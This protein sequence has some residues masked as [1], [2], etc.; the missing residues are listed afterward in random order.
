MNANM[1]NIHQ[2]TEAIE[3]TR[4]YCIHT[5]KC[6]QTG[7]FSVCPFHAKVKLTWLTVKDCHLEAKQDVF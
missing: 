4:L 5:Y 3:Q 1:K 7:F 2:S 6:I